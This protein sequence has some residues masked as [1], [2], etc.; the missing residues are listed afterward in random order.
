MFE[1]DRMKYKI[2][3][4]EGKMC[5]CRIC[6]LKAS[7]NPVVRYRDGKFKIVKLTFQERVKEFFRK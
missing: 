3:A 2:K 6:N 4:W 1:T 7:S 5:C